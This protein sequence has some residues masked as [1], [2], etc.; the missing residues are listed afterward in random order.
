MHKEV[1]KILWFF[2]RHSEASLVKGMSAVLGKGLEVCPYTFTGKPATTK[3][4]SYLLSVLLG[5]MGKKATTLK[6]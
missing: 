3:S 5:K 2:R 6:V 4:L 1:S